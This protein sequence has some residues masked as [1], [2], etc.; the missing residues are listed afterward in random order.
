MR[1]FSCTPK[2]HDR[3][4][5]IRIVI[6]PI[7]EIQQNWQ[8]NE[9]P[10]ARLV[11]MSVISWLLLS[12]S[13]LVFYLFST[14]ISEQHVWE[15]WMWIQFAGFT[16]ESAL[17]W[18]PV[19]D[20]ITLVSS[21]ESLGYI[22]CRWQYMRTAYIYIYYSSEKFRTVFQRCSARTRTRSL[23]AGTHRSSEV[24]DRSLCRVGILATDVNCRRYWGVSPCSA[25]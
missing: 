22:F 2:H 21:V 24:E 7:Q 15:V 1:V 17:R 5:F 25:R 20:P 13:I 4:H 9:L 18:T 14:D 3:S 23:T 19:N 6:R 16:L 11:S 8:T 12:S 10:V